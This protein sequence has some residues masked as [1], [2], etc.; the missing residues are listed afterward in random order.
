MGTTEE[1]SRRR[2][3]ADHAISFIH[4]KVG[5]GGIFNKLL[6]AQQLLTTAFLFLKLLAQ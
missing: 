5:N 4:L 3:T 6:R 2:V 1:R